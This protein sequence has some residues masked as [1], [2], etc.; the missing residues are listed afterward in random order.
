VNLISKSFGRRLRQIRRDRGFETARAFADL[1][2]VEENTLTR[3]ERGETEPGFELL[4][5]ICQVLHTT[6]DMLLLGSSQARQPSI[7][8]AKP[9]Q[10][11]KSKHARPLHLL[12]N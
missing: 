12:K 10:I 7:E 4:L 1:L 11:T 8:P 3:W 5:R 6:P 2:V 9:P